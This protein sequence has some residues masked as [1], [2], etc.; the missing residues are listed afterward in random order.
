MSDNKELK[1]IGLNQGENAKKI[2][3]DILG[4]SQQDV[5]EHANTYQQKISR[6]EKKREL[7]E[8]EK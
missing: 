2:R 7:N 4:D 5:A 6:M 3:E 1:E 8:I